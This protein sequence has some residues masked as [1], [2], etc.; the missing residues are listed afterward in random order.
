[1]TFEKENF[2]IQKIINHYVDDAKRKGID[3]SKYNTFQSANDVN[4]IINVLGFEKHNL[5]GGSYGTRLGRITQELHPLKLNSVILN[6]P[7]PL[8]GD[9]L[10]S[11]L[12]SY[13]KSL[14]R[15][16]EYCSSNYECSK[17]YPDLKIPITEF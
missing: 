4:T 9:M 12:I 11:R 14:S 5:Y 2:E 3:L 7:N 16:F 6:S 10:V 13:S 1:M 8:V 15:V 17:L